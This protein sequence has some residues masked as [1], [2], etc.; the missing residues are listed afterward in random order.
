[1]AFLPASLP[2]LPFPQR[3]KDPGNRC[4]YWGRSDGE[5]AWLFSLLLFLVIIASL[6]GAA[7][8]LRELITER[9]MCRA[10]GY[11]SQMATLDEVARLVSDL[12]EV[13]EGERFGNRTWSVGSKAFAWDRPFS[14]ADVRRFGDE[15]PPEGPIL[16]VRVGDLAEK[17][18]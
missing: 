6:T 10:G 8:S 9:E 2:S 12:P 3:A 18:A 13:T 17:E 1:M 4:L 15:T 5:D 16:A 7:S 14:K 11:A